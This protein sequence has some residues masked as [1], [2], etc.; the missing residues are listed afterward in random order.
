MI[1]FKG[2]LIGF[3]IALSGCIVTMIWE[4]WKAYK[5]AP[6]RPGPGETLTV[7]ISP[8]GVLSHFWWFILALGVAG[9]LI[10]VYLQK[11]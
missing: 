6:V 8:L 2:L 4:F 11:R 3:G 1:Y 5:D 7:S 10:S 9:F